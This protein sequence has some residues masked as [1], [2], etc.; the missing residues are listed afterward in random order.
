MARQFKR[1]KRGIAIILI[2]TVTLSE[3]VYAQAVSPAMFSVESDVALHA[4]ADLPAGIMNGFPTEAGRI[5]SMHQGSRPGLV[6]HIQDAHV[7]EAAQRNIARVLE[8]FNEHSGLKQ[9]YVEGAEGKLYSEIYSF[10]PDDK[11]RRSVA[12]FFLHEGRLSGTEYFEIVKQPGLQITGVETLGTYEKNRAAYFEA[13]RHRDRN[14]KILNEWKKIVSG[15][16]RFVFSPEMRELIR[17]EEK[18][19]RDGAWIDYLHF[20]LSVRDKQNEISGEFPKIRK[21]LQFADQQKQI[22]GDKLKTEMAELKSQLKKDRPSDWIKLSEL[23][24]ALHRK[25]LKRETFYAA[26]ESEIQ[27]LSQ[28]DRSKFE[29]ALLYTRLMQASTSLD[30]DFDEEKEALE[31]SVV[32]QLTLE[33]DA[34]HLADLWRVFRTTRKIFDLSLTHREAAY[35]MD[36]RSSFETSSWIQILQPLLKKFAFT[37]N[38]PEYGHS[39]DKALEKV[40]L[41]YVWALRRDEA[42]ILNAISQMHSERQSIAAVITGGF[43]SP[44]IES[45]LKE[46]DYSYIVI[47]PAIGTRV[48]NPRETELYSRALRQGQI[49]PAENRL[50]EV[51]ASRTSSKMKNARFQLAPKPLFQ[52]QN[53]FEQIFSDIRSLNPDLRDPSL[54]HTEFYFRQMMIEI[55]LNA[56]DPKTARSELRK[57]IGKKIPLPH[58][59]QL[60]RYLLT[61]FD[62]VVLTK[63]E[64]KKQSWLFLPE[65]DALDT[66]LG[67]VRYS[68]PKGK[69]KKPVPELGIRW[70]PDKTIQLSGETTL[71]F[72]E[73]SKDQMERLKTRGESQRSELRIPSD[74]IKKDHASQRGKTYK[75][76]LVSPTS[77]LPSDKTANK[78]PSDTPPNDLLLKAEEK[79]NGELVL[80]NPPAP[81]LSQGP[82]GEVPAQG[83]VL[84]QRSATALTFAALV[85]LLSSFSPWLSI[86]LISAA[87]AI[88]LG[89]Q[90][91]AASNEGAHVLAALLSGHLPTRESLTGSVPLFNWLRGLIPFYHLGERPQV[92]IPALKEG[93]PIK[94]LIVQNFGWVVNA[95]LFSGV[96]FTGLWYYTALLIWISTLVPALSPTAALLTTLPMA[97]IE[98]GLLLALKDSLRSDFGDVCV[99][100]VFNCGNASIMG[101]VRKWEDLDTYLKRLSNS[102]TI[103]DVRGKISIGFFATLSDGTRKVTVQAKYI[104]EKRKEGQDAFDDF[105]RKVR[106]RAAAKKITLSFSIQIGVHLRYPTGGALN[107]DSTVEKIEAGAHPHN[108]LEKRVSML[109]KSIKGTWQEVR[110]W[111]INAIGHNGDWNYLLHHGVWYTNEFLG[112][113]LKRIHHHNNP[114][115]GDSPKGAGVLDL[116]YVQGRWNDTVR[117]SHFEAVIDKL[118]DYFGGQ[119]PKNTQEEAL[120]PDTS[121]TIKEE[122]ALADFLRASFAR[123][124]GP[125]ILEGLVNLVDISAASLDGLKK[126]MVRD[127]TAPD[128]ALVSALFKKWGEQKGRAFVQTA[129]EAYFKNDLFKSWIMI[130][131]R[132]GGTAGINAY[133][134]IDPNKKVAA[135]LGQPLAVGFGKKDGLLQIGVASDRNAVRVDGYERIFD[136]NELG[137]VAEIRQIDGETIT[138]RV[139]SLVLKREL[140][141]EE[142][143]ARM[144]PVIPIETL[145]AKEKK[146]PLGA[147]FR[148]LPRYLHIADEEWKGHATKEVPVPHNPKVAREITALLFRRVIAKKISASVRQHIASGYLNTVFS[149]QAENHVEEFLS[150]LGL[151]G[152]K[153]ESYRPIVKKLLREIFRRET[154]RLV[155]DPLF[156]QRSLNLAHPI[157]LDLLRG[158]FKPEELNDKMEP[159]VFDLLKALRN[160]NKNARFPKWIASHVEDQMQSLDTNDL[161][162]ALSEIISSPEKTTRQREFR[163]YGRFLNE[164]PSEE[165]SG[166]DLFLYAKEKN[167]QMMYGLIKNILKKILPDFK[168]EVVEPNRILEEGERFMRSSDNAAEKLEELDARRFRKRLNLA[169]PYVV[170]L[171]QS[172]SGQNFPAASANP[173]ITR[174]IPEAFVHTADPYSPMAREVG[175]RRT[176]LI[177]SGWSPGEIHFAASAAI[178]KNLFELVHFMARSFVEKFPNEE[179]YGRDYL[180]SDME[181]IR[182]LE[183][184]FLNSSVPKITGYTPMGKLEH[185][186]VPDHEKIVRI[187]Q[188]LGRR[189]KEPVAVWFFSALYIFMT[190]AVPSILNWLTVTFGFHPS[191]GLAFAIKLLTT[192]VFATLNSLLTTVGSFFLPPVQ[193]FTAVSLVIILGTFAVRIGAVLISREAKFQSRTFR[194]IWVNTFTLSAI[195][196]LT[197]FVPGVLDAAFYI[198]LGTPILP[199]LYRT[200]I[201]LLDHNPRS[202]TDRAGPKKIVIISKHRFVSELLAIAL[203]KLFSQSYGINSIQVFGTDNYRALDEHSGDRST[204]IILLGEDGRIPD[205]ANAE[206]AT[207]M[208]GRQI[209]TIVSK[210]FIWWSN[211]YGISLSG[212]H[213]I[214]LSSNPI[215]S[216][217]AAHEHIA[218]DSET[219]AP[220]FMSPRRIVQELFADMIESRK[221][222][223]EGF[224]LI[225]AMTRGVSTPVWYQPWNYFVRWREHRTHAGTGVH[226][227]ASGWGADPFQRFLQKAQQILRLIPS[228]EPPRTLADLP[229]YIKLPEVETSPKKDAFQKQT[230][231]ES[232]PVKTL[233]PLPSVNGNGK[234]NAA[235]RPLPRSFIEE[236]LE[237]DDEQAVRSELRYYAPKFIAAVGETHDLE[238][239]FSPEEDEILALREKAVEI[240]LDL[241]NALRDFGS[242]EKVR[243]A[244]GIESS[245]LD[246]GAVIFHYRPGTHEVSF[247]VQIANEMKKLPANIQMTIYQDPRI[248][249]TQWDNLRR[250]IGKLP[251]LAARVRYA[252]ALRYRTLYN[253]VNLERRRRKVRPEDIL[254]LLDPPVESNQARRL[255][256]AALLGAVAL[257]RGRIIIL[258]SQESIGD[259]R[260]LRVAEVMEALIQTSQA[261]G[262]SA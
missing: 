80:K 138:F 135:A 32:S 71:R 229:D 228:E 14:V 237:L 124:G 85:L 82:Q 72:A 97:G 239:Q 178:Q 111:I 153:T 238:R 65:S 155:E 194:K 257:G 78:I 142:I 52:T 87:L 212:A 165:H 152:E 2:I 81:I 26:M 93:H 171:G 247:V 133:S 160:K 53:R 158:D 224:V 145:E 175:L 159:A 22:H 11:A 244:L 67:V 77:V 252:D 88:R 156:I 8:Y 137:E 128:S 95:A 99:P 206:E 54:A 56:V 103:T 3:L 157:A 205:Q 107:T 12:D 216:P 154:L 94:N 5:K 211:L 163:L 150:R 151:E 232:L 190:V 253:L 73:V 51:L 166:V 185:N 184:D 202:I 148:R 74:T 245:S 181:E 162:S 121:L 241:Q 182:K 256:E 226:T 129:V 62:G 4:S 83:D 33:E 262:R 27:K 225:H 38:L 188:S 42:L 45:Y 199:L 242:N 217:K 76:P 192:P 261:V 134:S 75:G 222:L 115:T 167:E 243:E 10:F 37:A 240:D 47:T 59:A 197:L 176:L 140:T 6:V 221:Q 227:T 29:Q 236:I 64:A 187:A 13:T 105:A 17:L 48:E 141:T 40:E 168:V 144:L 231:V 60:A 127:I 24:L 114:T 44:G 173:L 131:E 139:Y 172:E 46:Q 233:A 125:R 96:V 174:V 61:P 102:I 183:D 23:S 119:H 50:A 109:L 58:R 31:E 20:L 132:F 186:E 130:M 89:Y 189:I 112:W 207:L 100:G 16:S 79:S 220:E 35:F 179:L 101:T 98:I 43:H 204:W 7:N 249:M 86:S 122:E 203:R 39:L 104:I 63:D 70:T 210:P 34:G 1:G 255:V 25:K 164:P 9:V 201:K 177:R 117:F 28:V 55:F 15:L 110:E 118:E 91:G 258:G 208:I 30:V 180:A 136:L 195:L 68:T 146:D 90:I 209:K 259:S 69:Q 234:H 260:T 123:H 218:I 36:H 84:A 66:V 196:G 200:A 147:E 254:Q 143:A 49:H 120:A 235:P 113:A 161:R 250:Q 193:L 106:R 213:I 19:E 126:L 21:L 108:W 223:L 92:E 191:F 230:Q 219:H 116:F 251:E 198:F 248:T 169:N 57:A 18:A 214:N 149:T 170:A 246:S 215:V 41:F